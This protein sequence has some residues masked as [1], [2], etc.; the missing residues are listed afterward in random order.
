MSTCKYHSKF[1]T[2][3]RTSLDRVHG[4]AADTTKTSLE[5]LVAMDEQITSL[6]LVLVNMEGCRIKEDH[7]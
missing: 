7:S 4:T 1:A 3:L 6:E 5:R 2:I